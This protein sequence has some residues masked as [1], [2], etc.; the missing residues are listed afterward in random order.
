MKGEEG[1]YYGQTLG[2]VSTKQ[3]GV[4]NGIGNLKSNVNVMKF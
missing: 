2:K 3:E 1:V 4:W